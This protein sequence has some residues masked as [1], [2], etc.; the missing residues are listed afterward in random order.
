M[1]LPI[2][3]RSVTRLN[4]MRTS[5]LWRAYGLF[6]LALGPDVLLHAAEQSSNAAKVT[7]AEASKFLYLSR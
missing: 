4:A 1:Q 2:P 7:L 6:A 3:H 5:E